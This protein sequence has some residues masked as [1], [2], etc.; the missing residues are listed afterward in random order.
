[1]TTA[2]M[3]CGLCGTSFTRI[4]RGCSTCP[5][6]AGCDLVKCPSCGFQFPRSS[7]LID[8][9]RSVLARFRRWFP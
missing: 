3:Q 8:W 5:L 2:S 7:R 6:N 9:A 4:E 1:M